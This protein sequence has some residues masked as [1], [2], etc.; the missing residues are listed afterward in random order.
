MQVNAN[1][2]V[3]NFAELF[4]NL[5]SES[6]DDLIVLAETGIIDWSQVV[7]IAFDRG[8]LAVVHWVWKQTTNSNAVPVAVFSNDRIV[9]ASKLLTGNTNAKL[10]READEIAYRAGAKVVIRNSESTISAANIM[11]VDDQHFLVVPIW[12][13]DGSKKIHI[14]REAVKRILKVTKDSLDRSPDR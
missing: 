3:K 13:D 11:V 14:P 8:E 6:T 2:H 10:N 9:K 5:S 7:N 4:E 1:K 12:Y